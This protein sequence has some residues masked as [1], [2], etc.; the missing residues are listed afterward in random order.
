MR[1]IMFLTGLICLS[2]CF[3][4]SAMGSSGAVPQTNVPVVSGSGAV[5]KNV[6]AGIA[7]A[8]NAAPEKSTPAPEKLKKSNPF[9]GTFWAL[10]P[11]VLA[12]LL[13]LITKE[14]Y[15]S[16]F[17][18]ILLGG[19]F[20]SQFSLIKTMDCI[21]MQGLIDAIKATSGIFIFLVILGTI[22]AMINKSGAAAAF[23]RWTKAHV[24]SR[25]GTILATVVLGVLIFVDDYFN[26]L[27]VGSV[28]A[29]ATDAQKISRAK[30]AY[31]IDATAAPVC[32]I[33]PISS[34]AAAVSQ[35]A[36]G[37]PYSGLELFIRSIPY[38]FYSLLTLVFLVLITILNVDYGPMRRVEKMAVES[39][40][41]SGGN[42]AS[43]QEECASDEKEKCKGKIID[44]IFPL[45]FLTIT[46][47]YALIHVGGIASGKSFIAA[48]GDTDATVGLPWGALV[49]L[50]ICIGYMGSRRVL[51]MQD[52]VESI[53]KGFTLMVPAILI[54]TLATSLKNM[55]VLLGAK[56]FVAS[57]MNSTAGNLA[58]FLP[59]VIFLVASFL[60]FAT[61]TS[62]GTF[63]ILIPIVVAIFPVSSPLLY[64]GMSACL[65][66]A[67]CGDHCSPIS[68]TTIMA[69][70]GAHCDHICH[71]TTQLPYVM[72]V[73][74]VSFIGFLLAGVILN[75]GIVFLSCC[76][77]LTA[78]LLVIQWIEKRREGKICPAGK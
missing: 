26:C 53:V 5:E 59:A 36:S 75:W 43:G 18:G 72:I 22:V 39:G 60:A 46:C 73:A 78:T 9:K 8:N 20:S 50:V 33:A 54:L 30:L 77:L 51:S 55:T 71:V 69:S 3:C 7:P 12:I 56:D 68:D 38:N 37:T 28:M 32:M 62:W 49:S 44:I 41:L 4:S 15:S 67:V 23:G 76:V 45:L 14:V 57:V 13:A 66:G 16:L 74:A 61:G 47:V 21:I 70:A 27:T 10:V 42:A 19:L 35:Y 2:L 52:C 6:T 64:I 34:W 48:F 31:I 25:R 11:P 58:S 29:P 24:K 17:M 1:K 63:G 65:A 40:N